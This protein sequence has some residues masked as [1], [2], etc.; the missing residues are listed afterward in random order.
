MGIHYRKQLVERQGNHGLSAD[1]IAGVDFGDRRAVQE[2][3]GHTA[4]KKSVLHDILH[5]AGPAQLSDG[6][7]RIETRPWVAIDLV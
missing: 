4:R 3:P 1:F 5:E 2:A 7:V 6:R